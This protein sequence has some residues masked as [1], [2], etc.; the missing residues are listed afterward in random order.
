MRWWLQGTY[1]KGFSLLYTSVGDPDPEPN[2]QVF[3]AIQI[4]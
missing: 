1:F 3:L 2:P 4:H